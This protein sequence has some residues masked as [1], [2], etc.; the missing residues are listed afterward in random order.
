MS[1]TRKCTELSWEYENANR[2]KEFW[3]NLNVVL[4]Y[5]LIKLKRNNHKTLWCKAEKL[6]WASH[7]NTFCK[8]NQLKLRGKANQ[9]VPPV[10]AAGRH[11]STCASP[12]CYL[13]PPP[14]HQLVD[15]MA[16]LNED[17]I[18]ITSLGRNGSYAM[19]CDTLLPWVVYEIVAKLY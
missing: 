4:K 17:W 2:A 13:Q 11:I 19:L 5:S 3:L 1:Q 14:S 16:K 12:V 9:S 15:A 8:T 7:S 18:S 10:P 6:N